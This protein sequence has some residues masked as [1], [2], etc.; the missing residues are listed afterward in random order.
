MDVHINCCII[1]RRRFA[2][3][4]TDMKYVLIPPPRFPEICPI[5]QRSKG[6]R[7]LLHM[8][9]FKWACDVVCDSRD[10]YQ[11]K[12][13]MQMLEHRAEKNTQDLGKNAEICH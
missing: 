9:H 5:S 7:E 6:V 13:A 3:N 1:H 2:H 4:F 12:F 11:T 10:I 8:V